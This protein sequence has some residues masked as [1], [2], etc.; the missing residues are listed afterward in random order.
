MDPQTVAEVE[1]TINSILCIIFCVLALFVFVYH[2][3]RRYKLYKEI[4]RIPQDLL[5]LE[6]YKNLLKNLK[7][8]CIINNFIIVILSIEIILNL[9]RIFVFFKSLIKYFVK[10]D[11]FNYGSILQTLKNLSFSELET[12][13]ILFTITIYCS[14]VPIL[15]MLM[16]FLWLVYRKYEYK[17]SIIK[18]T[19]YIVL[20]T[21]IV[22]LF[23][24]PLTFISISL[25]YQTL[26]IDL[27]SLL[28]GILA[29]I[30]LT[31]FVCYARKFYL[32]LKS[33]EK[34][35]RLFYFDEK[36][37]LDSKL[38]R[39]HFKITTIFVGIAIFFFTLVN[40]EGLF[41]IFLYIPYYIPIPQPLS[42]F[43]IIICAF[44][45]GFI[46]S[47]SFFISQVL[48]IFNYLYIFILVVYKSYRD[49][50]K[51][52]NINDYIRP[53]MKQYHENVYSRYSG[54]DSD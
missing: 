11:E 8:K 10:R 41:I 47:F 26:Y 32:H 54:S 24:C 17:Y 23:L 18:W 6:E 20:R 16:D 5:I 15:S 52:E 9:G 19:W 12:Y 50:Q 22:F 53:I 21:S 1:V 45:V 13:S 3:R 4:N 31:Q 34:E 35:I 42:D 36:A 33:R 7:I 30:D 46:A 39:I 49:R 25:G 48:F 38:I 43:I 28:F 2:I 44:Y 27:A 37:Y 14:F 40:S 29:I 51:L